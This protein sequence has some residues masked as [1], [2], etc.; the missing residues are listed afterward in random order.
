MQL[1]ALEAKKPGLYISGYSFAKF[2][3]Q[4]Q[5][6]GNSELSNHWLWSKAHF[7]LPSQCTPYHPKPLTASGSPSIFPQQKP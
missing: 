2:S 1:D 5:D 6:C 7:P 4:A 3:P